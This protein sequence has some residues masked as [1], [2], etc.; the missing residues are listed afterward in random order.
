MDEI[1]WKPLAIFMIVIGAIAFLIF[2][3]FSLMASWGNSGGVWG[4]GMWGMGFFWIFPV[5]GFVI[6]LTMM[7][8]FFTVVFRHGGPMN[9]MRQSD[10]QHNHNVYTQP[11]SDKATKFC[12]SCGEPVESDWLVCPKCLT[13]LKPSDAAKKST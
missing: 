12:P 7:I 9:W 1:N 13:A 10:P 2:L 5:F 11:H 3:G 4:P 6:M 8:F